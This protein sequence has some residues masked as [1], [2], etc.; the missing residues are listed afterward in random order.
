MFLLP[1][2]IKLLVFIRN[3][4]FNMTFETVGEG[5]GC[6]FVCFKGSLDMLSDRTGRTNFSFTSKNSADAF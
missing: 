4:H 1:Y 6:L 5:F 2:P 3:W